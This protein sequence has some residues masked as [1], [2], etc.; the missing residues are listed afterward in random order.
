MALELVGEGKGDGFGASGRRRGGGL[1]ELVEMAGG[2]GRGG[3]RGVAATS[4]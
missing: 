3:R 2:E 1:V 4:T